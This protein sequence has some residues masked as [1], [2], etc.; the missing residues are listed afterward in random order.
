MKAL[1]TA[2]S[3]KDSQPSVESTVEGRSK[4]RK[5]ASPTGPG[6]EQARMTETP[7]KS[8]KDVFATPSRPRTTEAPTPAPANHPSEL[9]PYDSPTAIRRLFSPSV[10]RQDQ[11]PQTPLKAA[12]GPTPQRDGKAL[13]LFD[14]LS[15][16]G[17]STATPSAKRVASVQENAVQTP[18]RRKGMETI[19][20][21]N[22]EEQE[23]DTPR[24]GRTPMSGKKL[25][26]ENLFATPTTLKYAA[27]VED[28]N[29]RRVPFPNLKAAAA[30]SDEK[31]S[32][33]K[34]VMAGSDTPSF[35]RRS[36][37]GRSYNALGPASGELSPIAA[38][39]TRPFVGRGLSA[40][41]QGLRDMEEERLEEDLDVLRELEADQAAMQEKESEAADAQPQ[42][43]LRGRLGKR[44]FKKKGQKRTTRRVHMKPVVVPK[45][46]KKQPSPELDDDNNDD[47]DDDDEDKGEESEFVE[48]DG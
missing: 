1:E 23:E 46:Q 31:G 42:V 39:K 18:S 15:E 45:S 35:L 44:P 30:A 36:N 26:L 33:K 3:R 29:E 24:G 43:K 48:S 25:Y 4:K 10:H 20:E 6:H 14:L 47:D 13:G 7:R 17:G 40:L 21:E 5:H 41:V 38:R 37:G 28:E 27:M 8:A 11:Q 12:V 32:G 19:T 16:S 2:K 22:E 9:D 34:G